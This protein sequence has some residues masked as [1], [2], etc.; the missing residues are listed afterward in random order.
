MFQFLKYLLWYN[1]FQPFFLKGLLII[2]FL[3]S[4]YGYYWYYE[5]LL[6]TPWP[7]WIFTP[8]SPLSTSLFTLTLALLLLGKGAS[9]KSVK[10]VLG[11]L[12]CAAL[13]KYGLWAVVVIGDYWIR[14][15]SV[16][17]VEALLF[18]SHLGMA[19]QGYLF[20]RHW[21]FYLWQG[22]LTGAWLILN[23]YVDYILGWHPYLFRDDQVP[24]AAVTALVLSGFWFLY[25]LGRKIA[26]NTEY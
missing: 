14:G 21:P 7:W 2:N 16:T 25:C 23:D 10:E 18:L 6:A 3:G 17:L 20:L 15:A 11:L 12:A 1:P 4:L 22:L 13:I 26:R 8:D 19:A 9:V 5:Q 24:L